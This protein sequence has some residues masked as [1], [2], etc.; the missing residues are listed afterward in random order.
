MNLLV[1]GAAGFIGSEIFLQAKRQGINVVG[2]IHRTPRKSCYP[3][4]LASDDI[5]S[6][7][8]DSKLIDR[9]KE[10]EELYAVAASAYLGHE[11]SVVRMPEAERAN[12]SGTQRL[13]STLY[14]LGVKILWYSTEQVFSGRDGQ[15]PY[16]EDSV[17]SPVLTYGRHKAEIECYIREHMPE[18][19]IYR[20]SQNVA[21]YVEGV[22]IFNDVY[23]RYK[24]GER[25]FHSIEGQVLSPTDVRDT[26]HWSIEGLKRNLPGGIYHCASPIGMSR[27]ELVSKFLKA[28]GDDADVDEVPLQFFNFKEPRPLDT[29]LNTD[30]I[31]AA[32]PDIQFTSMEKVI[33]EFTASLPRSNM[34]GGYCGELILRVAVLSFVLMC[35]KAVKSLCAC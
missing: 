15:A 16:T 31:Q 24:N 23:N 4:D 2:T 7:L 27:S 32:M 3:F 6:V 34:G 20:L 17:T 10:G 12:L 29:R 1:I 14:N 13:L 30:K 11:R 22:H 21:P 25:H 19:I 9:L 26:A 18:I 8:K 33:E 5:L 28:I 35:M